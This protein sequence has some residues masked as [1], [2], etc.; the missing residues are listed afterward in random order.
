MAGRPRS[1][2]KASAA[3]SIAIKA[4]LADGE[5]HDRIEVQAA[6]MATVPPMVAM[7][8]AEMARRRGGPEQRMV[9][10]KYTA[11]ASGARQVVN[12]VLYAMVKNGSVE[13]DGDR[14]RCAPHVRA[15]YE[16]ADGEAAV[17]ALLAAAVERGPRG[18]RG[19]PG[20]VQTLAQHVG[21]SH[22]TIR[23]WASGQYPIKEQ[24]WPAME[25]FL[26][27]EPGT[28]AKTMTLAK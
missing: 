7:R 4:T 1:V 25:E 2:K 16:Q 11:V 8:R 28:I 23:S 10:D 3:W 24:Y 27:W 13:R 14:F 20:I 19:R 17:A 21:V 6:G 15:K 5:W 12:D 9:G 22:V 26:G 18:T